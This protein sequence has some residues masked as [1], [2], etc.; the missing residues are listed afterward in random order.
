MNFIQK[1]TTKFFGSK[2]NQGIKLSVGGGSPVYNS[3]Y[4]AKEAL[5]T[6]SSVTLKDGVVQINATIPTSKF[7]SNQFADKI[8]V[9]AGVM[10]KVFRAEGPHGSI[11]SAY[12]A[13]KKAKE[14]FENLKK[15]M[16]ESNLESDRINKGISSLDKAEFISGDVSTILD[17]ILNE[18]SDDHSKITEITL[19]SNVTDTLEDYLTG[20]NR[21][22]LAVAAEA[23]KF[24][25]EDSAPTIKFLSKSGDIET[26]DLSRIIEDAFKNDK[27][28]DE[29]LVENGVTLK[30]GVTT[31]DLTKKNF[32]FC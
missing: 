13:N 30:S 2:K 15:E 10:A 20:T 29:C 18:I 17:S 31:Q 8:E 9:G 25:G 22:S 12:E 19:A 21:E 11:S 5:T 28:A 6:D 27:I 24:S 1:L 4:N 26:A 23:F 7:I 16:L 32:R 14:S 3:S